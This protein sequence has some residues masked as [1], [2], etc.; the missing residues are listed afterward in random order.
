MSSSR[1]PDRW[2][3]I[4]VWGH[5][6]R[7]VVALAL[8][9]TLYGLM[10]DPLLANP[11]AGWVRTVDVCL[12]VVALA[13]LP[14][15]RRWPLAV[16]LALQLLSAFS[17]LGAGAAGIGLISVATR[18]RWQPIALTS[19]ATVLAAVVNGRIYPAV[20]PLPLMVDAG[21]VVVLIAAHVAWGLYIGARRD[22][23]ATWRWRAE[24]AE[25]EQAQRVSSAREGER[26]RIARE[27][28]DVL[29][30]RI[31][32]VSMHAGALAY[33]E[34]LSREQIREEAAIIH[35]T[36]MQA[37]AELRQILGVLR[38]T[39][40]GGT[41]ESVEAPQ[42]T[43]ADIGALVEEAGAAG[44]PT[45][46]TIDVPAGEQPPVA[47]GRHAYRMV[48][49]ALT[50]VCKHAPGADTRVLVRGAPGAGLHL[51][52]VNEPMPV[53]RPPS[54]SIGGAG[55]GLVGLAERATIVGGTLTHGPA[56]EGGYR[57]SADLPWPPE[58]S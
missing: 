45:H 50:N 2:E 33:R 14:L 20:D 18:R 8:G 27:M 34:D 37:L 1:A 25:R 24:T 16:P 35:G 55:L 10:L 36:S 40:V 30:H 58:D 17:V 57:V 26:T 46:L 54:A 52:V 28:H 41:E 22:L 15:H 9:L 29:A 43:F 32:L 48:Q 31:S 3:P 12:G 7:E 4:S 38:S 53:W 44:L 23:F 56:P 49:E 42:P 5:V 6:W 13:L 39:P 51:E 11:V 19:A 21:I 47:V